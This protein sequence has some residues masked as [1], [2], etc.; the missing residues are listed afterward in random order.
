MKHIVNKNRLNIKRIL[1]SVLI[2]V[3]GFNLNA[4]QSN[5]RQLPIQ[6]ENYL[7]LPS[8]KN[9]GIGLDRIANLNLYEERFLFD[10]QLIGHRYHF[11][12]VYALPLEAVSQKFM[13]D[14]TITIYGV[15]LYRKMSGADDE[16]KVWEYEDSIQIRSL[17][18]DTVYRSISISLLI[19]SKQFLLIRSFS[20]FLLYFLLSRTVHYYNKYRPQ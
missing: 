17:D 18:H 13:I 16:I 4:Q 1:I 2:F 14:S 11:D 12:S 19:L 3:L 8:F 15:A 6:P 20:I 5:D 9:V 10:V 7:Y